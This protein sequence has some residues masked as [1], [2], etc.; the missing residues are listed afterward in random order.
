MIFLFRTL[1]TNAAVES[2][3]AVEAKVMAD[4]DGDG[5]IGCC[6]IAQGQ[7]WWH[8]VLLEGLWEPIRGSKKVST[9]NPIRWFIWLTSTFPH[10]DRGNI[11]TW[12]FRVQ[13]YSTYWHRIVDSQSDSDTEHIDAYVSC[14]M[15]GSDIAIGP[16]KATKVTPSRHDLLL[17]SFFPRRW[18]VLTPIFP[19]R[20]A[21]IHE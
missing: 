20:T 1:G 3:V 7:W 11:Q 16:S 15:Y 10:G 8:V 2:F 4:G 17:S 18:S 5:G 14:L 12:I 13:L 9:E 6:D 21:G 19:S